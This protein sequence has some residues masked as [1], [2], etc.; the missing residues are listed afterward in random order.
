MA[1]VFSNQFGLQII[2]HHVVVKGGLNNIHQLFPIKERPH[3][4]PLS[5]HLDGLLKFNITVSADHKNLLCGSD[6]GPA[7]G[8]NILAGT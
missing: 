8:A 3:G 6:N 1:G 2:H 4:F 5:S 7:T